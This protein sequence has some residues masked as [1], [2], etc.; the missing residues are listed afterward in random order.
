[1]VSLLVQAF[2]VVPPAFD[3]AARR[4]ADR[5]AV[6]ETMGRVMGDLVPASRAFDPRFLT[7]L[8]RP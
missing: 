4:L 6:R 5:T 3:Y 1:M 7:A 8:L 2:L